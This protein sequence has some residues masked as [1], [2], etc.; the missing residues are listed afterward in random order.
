[1]SSR[2]RLCD[3]ILETLIEYGAD[4]EKIVLTC[5]DPEVVIMLLVKQ[6]QYNVFF[7]VFHETAVDLSSNCNIYA[8]DVRA[9]SMA[10][11]IIFTKVEGAAGLCENVT[12]LLRYP[13]LALATRRN[14]MALMSYGEKNVN[15]DVRDY[16]RRALGVTALICDN[17]HIV[18]RET[19]K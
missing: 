18:S 3:R 10:E 9:I 17:V 11:S 2:N 4:R 13:R 12:T 7:N 16:Q 14:G 19:Q 15:K 6:S 5:F 8:D 1:M